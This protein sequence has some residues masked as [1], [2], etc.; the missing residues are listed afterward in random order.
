MTITTTARTGHTENPDVRSPHCY[1]QQLV[2]PQSRFSPLAEA[3]PT[4]PA[5]FIHR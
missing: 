2:P 4:A 1:W 3:A 5:C